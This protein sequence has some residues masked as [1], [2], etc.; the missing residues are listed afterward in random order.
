MFYWEE[1][2]FWEFVLESSLLVLMVLGIRKIFIGKMRYAG[3]YALWLL[4]LVRFLVPVNFISTPFSA[5]T[6][7]TKTFSQHIAER[8]HGSDSG[9]T[10]N[11][12]LNGTMSEDNIGV[13]GEKAAGLSGEGLKKTDGAVSRYGGEGGTGDGEQGHLKGYYLLTGGRLAVSALLL[14][15]FVLSNVRLTRILRKSRV[16]YGER[17]KVKIYTAEGIQNPCLYGCFRP[18]IYLPEQLCSSDGALSEAE[19]LDQIITHEYVHFCHFDHIWAMF[20]V[21]LLSAY[22]FDPFL[23]LA[24]SC[25][26]K[27]AELFCDE[28]VIQRIGEENRFRY[29][30]MLIRLAGNP[31][32]GE[33][34]YPIM[35]MSRKGKEMERR[36]RAISDKKRY[37]RWIV[38][39]LLIFVL[40]AVGITCGADQGASAG[41]EQEAAS[42]RDSVLAQHF[43][44]DQT[45]GSEGEENQVLTEQ[46]TDV[47]GLSNTEKDDANG[48]VQQH[49]SA[50]VTPQ[51]PDQSEVGEVEELFQTYIKVFTEAVNTGNTDQL[52][53]V[54]YTGSDVYEQQCEMA[55][56]YYKRG[57]REK[58]KACSITSAEV[59]PTELETRQ[60]SISSKEK[61]RV[62]YADAEAKTI[63]QKYRYTCKCIE[64]RW[65]ITGMDEIN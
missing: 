39:P 42:N 30:K 9:L 48:F 12:T 37:S 16:L 53:Q 7:I 4:V 52:S 50:D 14:L 25:S 1:M 6:L 3:I 28:T 22:W 55:E 54:L 31:G 32:W 40:A 18:A 24:V 19:E 43:S 57:I 56:N 45:A 38:V 8:E 13:S 23:W 46:H 20:R 61:Y 27:D 35:P 11:A 36:I 26:K 29:A 21:L 47:A 49:A 10:V 41:E 34:R 44:S 2:L 65:M 58:V 60:M 63:K 15:W 59:S 51:Q 17:G 5:G 64:G 33:F 62:Y